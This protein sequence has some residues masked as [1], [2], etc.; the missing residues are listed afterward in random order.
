MDGIR[1]A[2]DD[3]TPTTNNPMVDEDGFIIRPEEKTDKTQ[4]SSCTSS[5]N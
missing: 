1:N 5:G 2:N 4:W 3:I